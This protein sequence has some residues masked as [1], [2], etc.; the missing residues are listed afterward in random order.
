MATEDPAKNA[1]SV[2]RK[3]VDESWKDSVQKEK[4]SVSPNPK[5]KPD[6][7][8][9]SISAD[10]SFPL[11]ISTLGM[12]VLVALGEVENPSTGERSPEPEQAKYLID[13]IRMLADKTKGNLSSEEA[14]M[15]KNLL[16][17]LQIKFVRKS[18]PL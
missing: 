14:A 7:E 5:S 13:V 2:L 1:E 15:I 18:R 12:Q 6:A 16:Y 3:K 8:A 17:E 10:A 9:E 11:F 4:E